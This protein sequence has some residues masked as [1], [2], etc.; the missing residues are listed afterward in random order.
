MAAQCWTR[1]LAAFAISS[2]R[3]L[4]QRRSGL[5]ARQLREPAV[6]IA[7]GFGSGLSPWAPGTVASLLAA[8]LWWLLLG[9]LGLWA[10]SMAVAAA[11]AGGVF[12]CQRV[13]RRHR[14]G[15]DPGIVVD[16]LV[17]CWIALLA[18]P[19]SVLW[20]G[21]A[22]LLFRVADIAKPWPVGWADRTVKG[23]LGIMLDDVLAGAMAAGALFAAQALLL[24]GSAA[25]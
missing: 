24:P 11:F 14:L 12:V 17:G 1:R 23:G 9:H 10:Q 6:L 3:Q 21:A 8:V 4:R 5:Q 7:T 16:E 18:A 15:D 2:S 20:A 19:R 22:L 13:V 25:G